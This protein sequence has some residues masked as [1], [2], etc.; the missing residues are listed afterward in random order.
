[1]TKFTLPLTAL[2]LACA[3]PAV[4]QPAPPPP[5]GAPDAAMLGKGPNAGMKMRAGREGMRGGMHGAMGGAMFDAL[6]PEGRKIMT[7][8]MASAGDTRRADHEQV[9]AARDRMMAVLEADRLDTGAL[10]RAMDDEQ[11]ASTASRSRMQA[12]MIA[13]FAKLT[14]ADRKAFVA[15]GRAMRNRMEA[16]M[17]AWRGMRGRGGRDAMTPPP[18]PPLP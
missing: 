11:A 4:A 8:A 3:A 6:S 16:R 9:R 7:D 15:Y 18:P 14:P 13:G 10:K 2:L 12:A 5:M 1:M 17:E